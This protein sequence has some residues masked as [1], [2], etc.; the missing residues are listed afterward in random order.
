[1]NDK[2]YSG[3]VC[4]KHPDLGGERVKSN[5]NCISCHAEMAAKTKKKKYWSSDEAR[6]TIIA[7]VVAGK[8]ARRLVDPEYRQTVFEAAV[9]RRAAKMQRIPPWADRTKIR[10]IYKQA[11]EQGLTVDHIIPLRGKLV[12][13]LHVENNLQLMPGKLNSSKGNKFD[14]EASK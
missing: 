14:L 1:M 4:P 11:K 9:N 7:R 13:G 6:Q 5:Y 10:A 12:S 3:K 8:A 2:H